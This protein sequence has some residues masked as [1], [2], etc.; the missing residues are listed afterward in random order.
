M[1]AATE[2][3]NDETNARQLT[4]AEDIARFIQA[5]NAT[6]TIVSKVTG[7]RFTYRVKQSD[8]PTLFFVQLLNGPDNE[9]SYA[10]LGTIGSGFWKHGKKS[11]I[12]AD[13]PSAKAFAWLWSNLK[14]GRLP[15]T[16]EFWH[17]G[18]CCRC[19]RKL[20]VPSSI[21]SGVG[22]E[23]AGRMNRGNPF[24]VVGAS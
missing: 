12:S 9:G 4:V 13:A 8:S 7:V 17:S 16:V 5:G 2:V 20:T 6:F 11:A 1:F 14:Q 3:T 23:C 15:D 22:P 10:Y 21:E 24:Q 19:N 18:R